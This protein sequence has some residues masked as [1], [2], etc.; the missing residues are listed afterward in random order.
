MPN[1]TAGQE[2][3]KKPEEEV[4]TNQPSASE[5]DPEAE[6]AKLLAENKRLSEE[7]ENY[8]KGMLK[9][10]GKLSEVVEPEEDLDAKLDQKI[11]E[12]LAQTNYARVQQQLEEQAIKLAR[13]NKELKKSLANRPPTTTNTFSSQQPNEVR[14]SPLSPEKEKALLNSFTGDE[15]TKKRKLEA[16]KNNRTNPLGTNL[17]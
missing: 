15:E 10:K 16:W 12:R 5:V 8:R 11:S 4:K 9:A 2:P 13:E 6:M 1:E 3:V 17:K 14:S 7:R